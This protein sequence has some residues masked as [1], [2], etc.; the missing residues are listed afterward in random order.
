VVTV[1]IVDEPLLSWMMERSAAMR[2]PVISMKE[3][4]EILYICRVRP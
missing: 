1:I 4:N 2:E 3:K